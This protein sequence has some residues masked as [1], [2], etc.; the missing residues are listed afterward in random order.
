[1]QIARLLLFLLLFPLAVLNAGA[2]SLYALQQSAAIIENS[3]NNTE[4]QN[5]LLTTESDCS[6][7]ATISQISFQI[8]LF[9]NGEKFEMHEPP[10]ITQFACSFWQPPKIS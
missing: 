1:M 10:F 5:K 3:E 2:S 7:E 4:N 8:G 6:E 9:T